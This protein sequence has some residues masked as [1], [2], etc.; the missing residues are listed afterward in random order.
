MSL[1]PAA[2]PFKQWLDEERPAVPHGEG[3]E[4]YGNHDV[5]LSWPVLQRI[6]P[7]RDAA[8]GEHEAIEGRCYRGADRSYIHAITL[9]TASWQKNLIEPH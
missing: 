1:T 4:R 3:D 5:R 9:H 2:K 7:D 8:Y 6:V